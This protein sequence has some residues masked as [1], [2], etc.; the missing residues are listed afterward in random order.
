MNAAK[1]LIE[2]AYIVPCYPLYPALAYALIYLAHPTS[3][4]APPTHVRLLRAVKS[5]A[6]WT[7]TAG[8]RHS[9]SYGADTAKTDAEAKYVVYDRFKAWL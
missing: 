7:C 6:R 4:L 1:G 9:D 2:S 5:L 8:T 3:L